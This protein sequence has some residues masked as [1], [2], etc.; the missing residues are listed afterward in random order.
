MMFCSA[1]NARP[2]RRTVIARGQA[3]ADIVV[4][5][6]DQPHRDAGR[7]GRAERLPGGPGERDVIV[8]SGSPATHRLVSS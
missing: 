4:A 6:A 5:V 1:T 3:L 8:L 7:Q 2:V